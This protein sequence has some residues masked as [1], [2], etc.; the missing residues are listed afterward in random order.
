MKDLVTLR[1]SIEE[2]KSFLAN[3]LTDPDVLPWFPLNNA[4]EIEDAVKIWVGYKEQGSAFTACYDGIPCGM[5]VVYL[6]RYKKL[7]HQALFAII[8]DKNF[9][10]KGIGSR[11][12]EHLK[13]MGK[14]QFGLEIL[15]LEVYEGN[16]A[17]NLYDRLGFQEYGRQPFF[18]KEPLGVYR[19]KI[20]M[21]LELK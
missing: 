7:K 12:I 18:L 21:Q 17:K 14:E 19:T 1:V 20:N 8:L 2:D 10:G 16:P 5:A 9:R 4:R 11:L 3:W 13:K 15:L 6:Q